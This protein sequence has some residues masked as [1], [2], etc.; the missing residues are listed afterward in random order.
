MTAYHLVEISF[1]LPLTLL[2]NTAMNLARK[3]G[4]RVESL[5]LCLYAVEFG[6]IFNTQFPTAIG[7]FMFQ[8]IFFVCAHNVII[9]QSAFAGGEQMQTN[10]IN[11]L[12]NAPNYS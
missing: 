7:L 3:S 1:L 10:E 8:I 11:S 4:V 12:I 6:F 9:S 5:R 2:H